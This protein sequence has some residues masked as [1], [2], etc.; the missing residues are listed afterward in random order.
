MKKIALV[1]LL[2]VSPILAQVEVSGGMYG[3]TYLPNFFIYF[4]NY[5]SEVEGKTR[6][7]VFLQ[8]PYGSVQFVKS[9][10]KFTAKYTISLAFYDED[11]D[12]LIFEKLWTEKIVSNQFSQTYSKQNYNISYKDFNLVPQKYI[13]I[14][15]I[16]DANSSNDITFERTIDVREI[17]KPTDISDI[18]LIEDRIQRNGQEQIVPSVSNIL[19]SD[20]Q[21]L[22]MFFEIYS[23]KDQEL[24]IDYK[25]ED[26]YRDKAH[27]QSEAIN[28]TT[29][30]NLLS[31]K[32]NNINLLLG[33]YKLLI[34]V[35]DKNGD[36][37]TAHGLN[38]RSAIT[39]FPISIVDLDN[40]I[41]QLDYI[42][43]GAVIDSLEEAETPEIKMALF[44]AFWQRKDPSPNTEENEVLI[45]YYRR[46]DYANKHFKGYANGGWKTDMGMVYI[47]LGPPD[48][49]NREPV[50]MNSKPYESWEFY[51]IQRTFWFVD[52]TGFG[53]FRL[54]NRDYGDWYRYRQ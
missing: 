44:R 46:I 48:Q 29:G 8:V 21:D 41:E 10:S 27:S 7:D 40:A 36:E 9:G 19:K 4:T 11:K 20:E 6:V 47:M 45:E 3:S 54:V 2:A 51:N 34:T 31:H 16:E 17:D 39:G 12:N 13:V 24:F 25:V 22:D 50:A 23:E 52:Q 42:A 30:V 26:K 14:C 15:I 33:K 37:L 49:V 28:V 32:M 1:L 38:F 43:N 35:K 18:V 53:D 5:Q